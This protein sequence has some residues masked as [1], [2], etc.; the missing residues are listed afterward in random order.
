MVPP[1]LELDGVSVDVGFDA[2]LPDSFRGSEPPVQ[3][4]GD[5]AYNVSVPP[6]SVYRA[7]RSDA[8]M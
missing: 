7:G 1:P 8:W 2:A 5:G 3:E 4:L 6:A